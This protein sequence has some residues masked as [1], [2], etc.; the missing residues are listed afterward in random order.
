MRFTEESLTG[1]YHQQR[2]VSLTVPLQ[3]PPEQHILALHYSFGTGQG[4]ILLPVPAVFE[5]PF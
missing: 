3:S 5:P 2:E 1:E 4:L